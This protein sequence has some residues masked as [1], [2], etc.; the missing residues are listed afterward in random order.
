[1]GS[2]I[3]LALLLACG[4]KATLEN[5]NVDGST[6]PDGR[7]DGAPGGDGP[8]DAIILGA[9]GTPA[10]VLGAS[11]AVLQEDDVSLNSTQTELYFAIPNPNPNGNK[12]L[13]LM[14][15]ATP[16]DAWGAKQPLTLFN[17]IAQEE[18]PRL[19]PNDL[20]LYFGRGGDIY[21]STRTAVGQPWSTPAILPGISTAVYEKWLAVCNNGY[22]MVS[23]ANGANGQDLYQGQIGVDN[24]TLITELSSTSSEISSFLTTDCLTTYFASNRSGTTQ[25][26]TATRASVT[27]AWSAPQMVN[28]LGTSTDNE[29]PW[30]SVDQRTFVFATV[31]APGTTK[32]LYISTR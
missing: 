24:G 5:G 22:F 32:D 17:T 6:N 18:S 29:D 8:T 15:R 9:W 20:T 11:D 31:R 13:Y 26:Y 19:A 25:L 14:T 23:R 10:P 16:Q 21:T 27:T 1:M 7:Y 28:S 2:R 4:C 12:D 30:M 3:V